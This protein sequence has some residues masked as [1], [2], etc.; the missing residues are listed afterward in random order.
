MSFIKSAGRFVARFFKN[1]FF[2]NKPI[3][4]TVITLLFCG[5]ALFHN[6]YLLQV[7]CIPV[8]WAQVACVCFIISLLVYPFAGAGLQTWLAAFLGLG[9][10]ICL[11]CILFLI[12]FWESSPMFY[13]GYFVGTL[14]YGFGL[15]AFLPLYLLWHVYKYT[16]Q[17]TQHER[18]MILY[19]AA[20]PVL[21][22][23]VYILPFK[24]N[25]DKITQAYAADSSRTHFLSHIPVNYFSER[26]LGTGFKYHTKLCYWYDGWRPP[27]HDPF[28]N[29]A[30]LIFSDTHYPF[31]SLKHRID[32]YRQLFPNERVRINCRCSKSYIMGGQ[33]YLDSNWDRWI[34]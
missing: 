31:K 21:C 28:Y 19:G 15:A 18:K 5:F 4:R 26:M 3:V 16:R 32:C 27:L 22:F 17:S 1:L 24:R 2:H 13:L 6:F 25:F 7:F 20:L 12:D 30:L 10:P 9:V 11:Y 33:H 8:W 23:A 29:T 34:P 14:F